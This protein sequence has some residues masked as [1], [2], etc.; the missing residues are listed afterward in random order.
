MPKRL[1][2]R[3]IAGLWIIWMIMTA[4]FGSGSWL[5]GLRPA[6]VQAQYITNPYMFDETGQR[7]VFDALDPVIRRWYLPQ[8]LYRQ[9]RW[10]PWEYSN[11]AREHYQ[12][13]TN[14]ALEGERWYDI[15]GNYVTH[16]WQIYDWRQEHPLTFGSAI[17]KQPQ[18]ASWFDN[19]VIASDARGQHYMSLTIGNEIRT[20]LTPMTFSKPAYSG[21]QW[22]YLS[23]KYAGTILASRVNH[24]GFAQTKD[25]VLDETDFTNMLAFR[26]T[27]QVGDFV[28]LGGTYI[29]CYTGRTDRNLKLEDMR[30][31]QLSTVQTGDVV[32][33]VAVR[34]LDDS[35]ED[36]R[37]GGALFSYTL[38][39]RR[40]DA[41]GNV[42]K[43]WGP[44]DIQPLIEGGYQQH[45]YL[46]ADGGETITLTYPI[47][48]PGL[49]DR[50]GFELVI[51][52]DF[53]VE[54]TSNLQTDVRG[55][56][57]YLPVT[58]AKG[59]VDDNSNQQVIRF[60]YGLPT[61]NEIYGATF[62]ITDVLGFTV[63]GEYIVNL[64]H[65]RF[66]NVNLDEHH[67][68]TDKA[69]AWYLTATKMAYPWFA[70]G[71]VFSIDHDYN[72]TVFMVDPSGFI[73]YSD[74]TQ[75][76]YEL[77]DD[78]DNQSRM[79]DWS[80]RHQRRDPAV[81]PGLDE[82]NDGRSDFNR[83][84]SLR[85]D[86][87]EPFLRYEVDPPEFLFGMDMNHNT[88]IDRFEDDEEPS[89]PYQRDRHGYNVYVGAEIVPDVRLRVGHLHQ[90]MWTDDRESRSY[91]TLFTLQRD[92]PRIGRI[93]FFE[94][95][96]YVQ[97]NIPDDVWLWKHPPGTR[98]QR[99]LFRDPLRARDTFINTTYLGYDYVGIPELNSNHKVKF[100]S[101][102]QHQKEWPKW[103]AGRQD[104]VRTENSW[105]LGLINKADYSFSL[106][107]DISLIPK[108][109]SMYRQE[110]IGGSNS[111]KEL[112]QSQ[113]L[114]LRFPVLHRS[115]IEIGTE[116]MQHWDFTDK[117]NDYDGLVLA[118][119]FS[120]RTHYMGY[121][122]I[123]NVGL[124]YERNVFRRRT[125][126]GTMAFV[127][128]FAG[129]GD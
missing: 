14:I 57:V 86:Y 98:G 107:G 85:P 42:V 63:H 15:Y 113:Y 68:S 106:P 69:H 32:R 43:E 83:N 21:L 94:N 40:I 62:E 64:Q 99:V 79:P 81:F 26:G 100:E 102:H 41:D 39:T 97:D 67:P 36:G 2:V 27:V 90:W 13:Y 9:Y 55:Y 114:I 74:K 49:V 109:K 35:P 70:Y 34:I 12:R 82:N 87:D 60:D 65:R 8:D 80:R 105:S 37:A 46:T 111:V 19:L 48:D 96:R 84:N 115:Q 31:G 123:T 125:E 1:H 61:G 118:G 17:L 110:K 112:T 126:A 51:S 24:P 108:L 50:I 93:Q 104:T 128:V 16:G 121:L 76:V 28:N 47:P 71:E 127:S 59:N 4:S 20:T 53:R 119:Q 38:W 58:R 117:F 66:P 77:V 25:F 116:T 33:W 78:N 101:Y 45:G 129:I 56:P 95:F 52:N 10:R 89:Y 18:Y 75:F 91:Y 124:S 29:N 3:G 6:G 92:Y 23:D 103:V 72:T 54:V 11:Y 7:V 22:D 88:I 30:R 73:D 122:L 5:T 120:N 44:E